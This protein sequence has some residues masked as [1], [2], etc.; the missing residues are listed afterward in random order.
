MP[1]SQD[2]MPMLALSSSLSSSLNLNNNNNNSSSINSSSS[3]SNH[4]LADS[5]PLDF[6][7]LQNRLYGRQL[8]QQWLREAYRESQS[9]NARVVL[10]HG[11][12]GTGK[13]SL[14]LQTLQEPV[15]LDGGVLVQTKFDQ[16]RMY[17]SL[18]ALRDVFG[19]LLERILNNNNP[20]LLL[21]SI[22][23]ALRKCVGVDTA[24][25][26]TEL[27]PN[28]STLFSSS[29]SSSSSASV[30]SQR[31]SGGSSSTRMLHMNNKGSSSN[32][33]NN[34]RRRRNRGVRGGRNTRRPSSAL[35]LAS[36]SSSSRST[37]GAAAATR[38]ASLSSSSSFAVNSNNNDNDNDDLSRFPSHGLDRLKTG[39]SHVLRVLAQH[40]PIVIL[41]DDLQ[42]ANLATLQII[43][44]LASSANEATITT[45]TTTTSG[46][47]RRRPQQQQQQQEQQKGLL[48]VGCYRDN[49]VTP[50]MA[51]HLLDDCAWGATPQD[52]ND[53]DDET[54]ELGQDLSC[55]DGTNEARK[56]AAGVIR[57][58]VENLSVPSVQQLLKDLLQRRDTSELA[59][60]VHQKTHGNAFFV[61]QFLESLR[62]EGLLSYS[63]Q[64]CR[65]EWE[66]ATRIQQETRVS[67]NV[68]QLLAFKL[69]RL[70]PLARDA[71][72]IGACLG[73]CFDLDV[74][75][76][77]VSSS[78][79][80]QPSGGTCCKNNNNNNNNTSRHYDDRDR[81]QQEKEETRLRVE[82]EG[83]I[84]V[85]VNEGLLLQKQPV[86]GQC[87]QYKFSHDR[88][89]QAAYSL[90]PGKDQRMA[91]HCKI[92]RYLQAQLHGEQQQDD[93]DDDDDEGD[94]TASQEWMVLVAA[95]QLN[96]CLPL[97][98][99]EAERVEMAE[100]NLWAAQ[101]TSQKSA[102]YASANFL[103]AGLQTLGPYKWASP[104][105][106]LSLRLHSLLAKMLY[107]LGMHDECQKTVDEILR[108]ENDILRQMTAYTIKIESLGSQGQVLQAINVAVDVLDRL[109][110]PFPRKPSV[111][112]IV[113]DLTATR[114]LLQNKSDGQLLSLPPVQDEHKRAAMEILRLVGVFALTAAETTFIVLLCLRMM[115]LPLRHGTSRCTAFGFAAYGCFLGNTGDFEG[116]FR[117][118]QLA[119]QFLDR[120]GAKEM[121]S[122]T[123]LV[124][125]LYL[126][127][128]RNPVHESLD[129]MMHSYEL[130][131]ETGDIKNAAFAINCYVEVYFIC[132][133]PLPHILLDMSRFRV[134][135][136]NY[137]QK[138]ALNLIKVKEQAMLNIAGESR[139]P[140]TL[141]GRVMRG[142]KMWREAQEN[143]H[144]MICQSILVSR[145]VLCYLFDDFCS[146][147]EWAEQVDAILNKSEGPSFLSAQIYFFLALSF[148]AAN[149]KKKKG[150][151]TVGGK[152]KRLYRR[153]AKTYTHKLRTWMKKGNGNVLHTVLILHAEQQ[154]L[155]SGGVKNLD[156]TKRMFD[157]AIASAVRV[158]FHSH[159]AMACERA[160][161]FFLE[162]DP[163]RAEHYLVRAYELYREW[164]ALGKTK[165]LNQRYAFLDATT[166]SNNNNNS[167]NK[168]KSSSKK[169][170]RYGRER[171]RKTVSEQHKLSSFVEHFP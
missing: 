26:L 115:L 108:N 6:G 128:L 126:T 137:Q 72:K 10:V 53:V 138:V 34:K 20:T 171:F 148:L 125:H 132:G 120:F 113:R 163:V 97:V 36:S 104:Y 30:L 63:L 92:G 152:K 118:G 116:A 67:D 69:Q 29:S 84:Q 43:Q 91:M 40:V 16:G 109:G 143:H 111:W 102:F 140:M 2:S 153:K 68:V 75:S 124:S 11:Y 164:G 4:L 13:T 48:I 31:P 25:A 35:L 66:D 110:E 101:E 8:E 32:N 160:G 168:T 17:S 33:H 77:V 161:E 141:S 47:R 89:Q 76:A 98:T 38:S 24:N 145:M 73:S 3:S 95:E 131:M 146:A 90:I 119:L 21:P 42:W 82:L 22:R 59:R 139:D 46:P 106:A 103:R 18:Q 169:V 166:L 159:A 12:S 158:G 151:Q 27:I 49:E 44:S 136:G 123:V 144:V 88:I 51:K 19:S 23:K 83:A 64:T 133:L 170:G 14:V 45:T 121:Y 147:A 9:K 80:Q 155:L 154:V 85:A 62:E 156:V 150:Q 74:V 52:E 15:S 114:R 60:I 157:E 105:H 107:C 162:I 65:W 129:A 70:P 96:H 28:L 54:D 1:E 86:R 39:L 93:D 130:G 127:H 57:I 50:E 58:R 117:F 55:L 81:D 99:E 5:I 167:D 41:W 87:C 61:R 135:L 94:S 100:L 7:S 78:L 149:K 56:G 71:I 112:Q 37:A 79:Q 122:Q 134:E 165:S 142:D